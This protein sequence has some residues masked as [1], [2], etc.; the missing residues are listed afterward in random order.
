MTSADSD[1]AL[2]L[3]LFDAPCR[4]RP[5]VTL[6]SCLILL[7]GVAVGFGLCYRIRDRLIPRY[8]EA[9]KTQ[10]I[11][12][13]ASNLLRLAVA[14]EAYAKTH[15]GYPDSQYALIPEFLHEI[16]SCPVAGRVTYRTSFGP[17]ATGEA[18]LIECC[19]SNHKLNRI[20][21]HYPAY[22]SSHGLRMEPL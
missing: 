3:P 9:G 18:F 1:G 15:G 6:L 19:G 13:C 14:F 2:P 16:P 20:A 22:Q 12:G 4:P 5:A 10:G 8:L 11:V 7:V 17:A 21:P